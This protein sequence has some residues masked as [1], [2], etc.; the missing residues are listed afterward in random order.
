MTRII[1]H[2]DMSAAQVMQCSY[3]A[4]AIVALCENTAWNLSERGE[5]RELASAISTAL[6]V[7]AML[8]E[9]V[10]EALEQHEGL[11]DHNIEP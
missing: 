5:N 8:L 6:K 10:H 9:P 7:V 1:N 4:M 11:A 2:Q 3:D